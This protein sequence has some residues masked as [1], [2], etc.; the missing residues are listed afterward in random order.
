MRATTV[1]VSG[2]SGT[3]RYT[4]RARTPAGPQAAVKGEH[5]RITRA[6][7][8]HRQLLSHASSAIRTLTA[9][10]NEMIA[11]AL[12]DGLTLATVSAVTG[13]NVR[14][15]RTIGLAYDDLHASGLPRNAQLDALKAK[16]EELK[17]AERHRDQ[18]TERREALIVMA[19]QTQAC[20]DLELASLTGLTQ[21]HIRRSSRGLARSA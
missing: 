15:V 12:E 18:I 1:S 14:A 4:Y 16:S 17:A 7:A 13:E 3:G 2:R 10:R 5:A 8:A 9:A 11:Q 20:D 6:L 21:D 19:L